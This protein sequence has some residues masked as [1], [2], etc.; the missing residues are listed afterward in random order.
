MVK[1]LFEREKRVVEIEAGT[2]LL[3]AAR[4]AGVELHRPTG[5][6]H[7]CHAE[8]DCVGCAVN[9][10]MGAVSD[11]TAMEEDLPAGLRLA[12]Q[13]RA[14]GHAVVTSLGEVRFMA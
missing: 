11:R 5:R 1:I 8:H 6:G 14:F 3:A 4:K 2:S 12:C 9:V 7:A 10:K 13:A